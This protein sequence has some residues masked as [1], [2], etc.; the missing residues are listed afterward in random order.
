MTFLLLQVQL[1]T[2]LGTSMHLDTKNKPVKAFL[3]FQKRSEIKMLSEIG[4]F[5]SWSVNGS[6]KDEGHQKL[7]RHTSRFKHVKKRL[8]WKFCKIELSRKGQ[9]VIRNRRFSNF[10][11]NHYFLELYPDGV[12]NF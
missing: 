5:R 3:T 12:N 10:I 4:N 8:F 7:Y 11:Q 2:K 6:R 1:E 9:N